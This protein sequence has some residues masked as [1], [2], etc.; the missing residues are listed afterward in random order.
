MR[1]YVRHNHVYYDD[2]EDVSYLCVSRE[3]S[4]SMACKHPAFCLAQ[5]IHINRSEQS[6]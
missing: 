6:H 1:L 4:E 3:R 5:R 2:L